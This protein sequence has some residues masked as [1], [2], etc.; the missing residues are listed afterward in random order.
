MQ[1]P[2]GMSSR[3]EG[4][5]RAPG[6]VLKAEWHRGSRGTGEECRAAAEPLDEDPASAGFVDDVVGMMGPQTSLGDLRVKG[7]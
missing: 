2:G 7:R 4:T 3:T 1:R 6:Q 5:A